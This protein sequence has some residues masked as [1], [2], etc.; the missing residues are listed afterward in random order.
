MFPIHCGGRIRDP[1]AVDMSERRENVGL[2]FPRSQDVLDANASNEQRVANQRS[3][4]AP[5]NRFGTHQ[6]TSF[7]GR[8]L[9]HLFD[10]LRE[11]RR[12]HVIRVA[13]KRPVFPAGVRGIGSRVAQASEARKMHVADHTRIQ[14]FAERLLV[15]VRIVARPRNGPDVDDPR[16]FVGGEQIGESIDRPIG[17][18]DGADEQ[19][20]HFETTRRGPEGTAA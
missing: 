1:R 11:L 9:D 18:P 16:N 4:T 7:T 13:T 2:P 3:V 17:V 8:Q 19:V 6:R 20:I 12:L 15:E 14:R 5:G 10:V